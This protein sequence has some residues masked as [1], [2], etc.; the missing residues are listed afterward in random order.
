MTDETWTPSRY[1]IALAVWQRN[2]PQRDSEVLPRRAVKT[3]TPKHAELSAKLRSLL[4]WRAASTP[5]DW[6]TIAANDNVAGEG[7]EI[8]PPILDSK[9]E[10]RPR[11]S[12]MMVAIKDVEFEERRHAR[13]G[14]GGESYVAPVGGDIE[15][16][17]NLSPRRRRKP[18][19]PCIWR[20]G[21]LRLSNGANAEWAPIRTED[22]AL[23][24]DYVR[25]PVGG[26]IGL[27]HHKVRD[28]F[29]KPK[30]TEAI[31]P[32]RATVGIG[33]HSAGAVAFA[34]PI[35]QRQESNRIRNGVKTETA[36]ILDFALVAANF[37]QIGE[38][39][40]Y[41]GKNAERRGK[42]ALIDACAEL[43]EVLA[44]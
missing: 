10:V 5:E 7:E 11:I 37:R 1:R 17:P 35:E 15:R 42:A 38:R 21:G 32:G 36:D 34:D 23:Q 25:I 30:G 3:E 4:T 8:A 20:L 6:K 43:D 24:M 16:G 31:D 44:A 13:L 33:G 19:P 40:G 22:G 12:E 29:G 18:A 14:G 41:R 26:I 27:G 2:A 9:H 28:R 39:L